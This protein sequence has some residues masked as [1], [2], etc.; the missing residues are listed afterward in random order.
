MTGHHRIDTLAACLDQLEVL[1][2]MT[3]THTL[4]VTTVYMYILQYMC[5]YVPV[6]HLS[7]F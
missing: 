5:E 2:S 1:L 3:L 6:F 4:S 7:R